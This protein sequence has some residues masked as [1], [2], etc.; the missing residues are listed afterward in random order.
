VVVV[1]GGGGAVDGGTVGGAV[2]GGSE[3]VGAGAVEGGAAFAF[4]ATGAE[5]GVLEQAESV[6][7]ARAAAMAGRVRFMVYRLLFRDG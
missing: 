7:A 3:V 6:S 2:A 5:L 1:G 4:W